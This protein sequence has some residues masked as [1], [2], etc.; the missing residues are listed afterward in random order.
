MRFTFDQAQGALRR[1]LDKVPPNAE[2]NQQYKDTL[3]WEAALELS[4]ELEVVLVTS[5]HGF[6]SDRDPGKGL[7]AELRNGATS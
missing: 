6:Y 2:K 3:I 7:A 1:V 5:D 4:R